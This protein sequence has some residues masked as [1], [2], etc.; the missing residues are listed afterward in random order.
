MKM[1]SRLFL[2]A[3]TSTFLLM[4]CTDGGGGEDAGAAGDGG[5]DGGVVADAGMEDAGVPDAGP[6]ACTE[7]DGGN[8]CG[9]DQYCDFSMTPAA[10]MKRCDA[11]TNPTQCTGDTPICNTETGMCMAR[12]DAATNPTTCGG[13]EVCN[14]T[15]GTCIA[16]CDIDAGATVCEAGDVCGTSGL[17]E[18]ECVDMDCLTA[19]GAGEELC[20]PATNSCADPS[21]VT[22]A[23]CSSFILASNPPDRDPAGPVIY[24]V[25]GESGGAGCAGGDTAYSVTF[26]YYD[27]DG[28][29]ESDATCGAT[30]PLYDRVAGVR[31]EADDTTYGNQSFTALTGDAG[32][33]AT[34]GQF[35]V[36]FCYGAADAAA[37]MLITLLDTADNPSN[38]A[39]VTY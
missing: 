36:T 31:K 6:S 21:E 28:D 24:M 22:E 19:V 27:A 5:D 3:T 9:A 34:E 4:G 29:A 1:F 37:E 30:C 25:S 20:D 32:N 14:T 13:D 33:T 23:A 26:H 16:R 15:D 39:C 11:P 17:C 8:P 7:A 18:P 12:C 2:A 10:C 38:S 35:T